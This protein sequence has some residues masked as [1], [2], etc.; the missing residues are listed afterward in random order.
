D[1]MNWLGLD[2]GGANLKL[3]D[4]RGWAVSRPFP[5]WRQPSGLAPAIA[6]LLA[7]AP[8]AARLAVTM[9]GEVADCLATERAGGPAILQA[10]ESAAASRGL[11]REALRV[12]LTSGGLAPPA[13]AREQPLRAAAANWHALARFAG[14]FVPHGPAVLIDIGS[15]TSD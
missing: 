4:G 6:E 12:Y 9:T 5:L 13:E 8:P 7:D 3:A 10:V 2:V 14:R 11:A 15:T 1:R